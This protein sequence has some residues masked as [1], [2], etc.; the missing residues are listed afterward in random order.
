MYACKTERQDIQCSNEAEDAREKDLKTEQDLGE[1]LVET[2]KESSEFWDS[3]RGSFK[4]VER[5]GDVLD[6]RVH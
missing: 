3:R 1:G 2:S 4:A 6:G 5:I